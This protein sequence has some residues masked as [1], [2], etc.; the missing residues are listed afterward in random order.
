MRESQNREIKKKYK[1]IDVIFHTYGE[2]Q[3]HS[4]LQPILAHSEISATQSILQIFVSIV[5]TVSELHGV[6]VGGLP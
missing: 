1:K 3:L 6:K 4:R 2:R 5:T